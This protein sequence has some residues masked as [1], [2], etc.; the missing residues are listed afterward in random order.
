MGQSPDNYLQRRHQLTTLRDAGHRQRHV[1]CKILDLLRI[2]ILMQIF[3][4]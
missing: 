3:P 4:A 2:T 1:I